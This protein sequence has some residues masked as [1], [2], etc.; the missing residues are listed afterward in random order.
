MRSVF[1]VSQRGVTLIELLVAMVLGLLVAGGILTV[2]TSTSSS[3][4]VQLQLARLQEDGRFA[5]NRLSSDVRM[6]NSQYCNNT[7]GVA[8]PS[9]AGG[10]L[11][12]LD[13]LRAP[14]VYATD[15]LGA[16]A[17]VT[18][19]WG[20]PYP[21]APTAAYYL[22]S[23]LYMRGYDCSKTACAPT[24]PTSVLPAMG[25]AAGSRVV[26]ADVLT[27]RYLDSSRGW[28]INSG[29]TTLSSS[30]PSSDPDGNAIVEKVKLVPMAGEPPSTDFKAGHLAML[31]DCTNAQV[32]S[33][34]GGGSVSTLTVDAANFSKPTRQRANNGAKV[35]DFNSDFNT[36]TY[37]L[38]VVDDGRG[39]TTGA[40]RR[41]VN[42]GVAADRGSDDEI[43]RGVERLDLRYG[44]EDSTGRT[45]FL[46][47]SDVDSR[48]SGGIVCPPSTPET[49]QVGGL[50]PGCLW[51]AVK[52][53]EV[54][55]LMDGQTPLGS[56]STADQAYVY[57]PDGAA[58]GTK[59]TVPTSHGIRP[60][61]DQGFPSGLLRR[62]FTVLVGVRNFNP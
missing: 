11:P 38:A 28:A 57:S 9:V 23:Y 60:L 27:L 39:G 61:E 47:A 17:D 50:E 46:T 26:G 4:Q 36:V 58:G 55:I 18:T 29:G 52:S 14:T 42:G 10:S 24:L 48:D 19:P 41:R 56:L 54:S 7:G 2:F 13:G 12:S 8:Q 53:I 43:A 21:G 44:V 15:L 40:L 37:Y 25:K 51:R 62:E 30:S 34:S 31:A 59:P 22:P 1:F 6:A 5:V 20:T 16:L 3:N 45:R 49:L 32:F 35:F 33:V